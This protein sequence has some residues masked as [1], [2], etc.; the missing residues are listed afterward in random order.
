MLQCSII[1]MQNK[2]KKMVGKDCCILYPDSA[3]EFQQPFLIALILMV[4]I[5]WE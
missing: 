1:I 2:Y 4:H 3:E 5:M